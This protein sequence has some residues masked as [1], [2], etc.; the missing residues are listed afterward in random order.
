MAVE[1]AASIPHS[2]FIRKLSVM[3]TN[4]VVGERG[5]FVGCHKESRLPVQSQR[6]NTARSIARCRSLFSFGHPTRRGGR[7]ENR[8][9]SVCAT[10]IGPCCPRFQDCVER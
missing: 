10:Q 9:V 2:Q 3:A 4:S 5:H 7:S 1:W 6:K 8:S